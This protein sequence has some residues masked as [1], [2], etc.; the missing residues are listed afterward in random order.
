MRRDLVKVTQLGVRGGARVPDSR[1]T[2][3]LV[4]FF[5]LSP[6]KGD[7]PAKAWRKERV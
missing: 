4:F 6:A 1:L 3:G 5:T 2:P 7:P